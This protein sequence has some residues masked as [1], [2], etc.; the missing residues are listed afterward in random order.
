MTVNELITELNKVEDKDMP[1]LVY[2][3]MHDLTISS[4]YTKGEDYILL[5]LKYPKIEYDDFL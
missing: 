4:V 3:E 5:R 1:V 2:A